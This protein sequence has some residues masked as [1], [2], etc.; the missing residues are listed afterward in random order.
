MF[1]DFSCKEIS[2]SSKGIVNYPPSLSE[3]CILKQCLLYLICKSA[4]IVKFVLIWSH[5]FGPNS[6]TNSLENE[7][8]TDSNEKSNFESISAKQ[9]IE[10]EE[11][12][13]ENPF[14]KKVNQI[15]VGK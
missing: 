2:F 7:K 13:K 5:L 3:Y 4:A 11:T 6:K 10:L 12:K 1:N 9:E 14:P 15:G 8:K